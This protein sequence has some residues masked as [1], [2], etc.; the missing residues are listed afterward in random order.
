[1]PGKYRVNKWKSQPWLFSS[2][3]CS[4]AQG[5]Y[6]GLATIRAYLDQKGERHRTVSMGRQLALLWVVAGSDHRVPLVLWDLPFQSSWKWTGNHISRN[7]YLWSDHRDA[8][9]QDIPCNHR[10]GRH[11][12][13]KGFCANPASGV[14]Q[15]A[16]EMVS[17]EWKAA[18]SRIAAIPAL[19]FG[20]TLALG[21]RPEQ[22]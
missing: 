9:F 10:E 12:E 15:L 22:F 11:L 17:R 4:G 13:M 21:L 8:C 3:L 7:T 19:L 2:C 20:E 1:M 6:A 5:E 16:S 18:G 14:S